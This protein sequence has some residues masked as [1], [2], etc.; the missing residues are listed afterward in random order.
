MSHMDR[1]LNG[2]YH[3]APTI[4]PR[5]VSVFLVIRDRLSK[6]IILLPV[7]SELFDAEGLAD[8]FIKNYVPHHW[9][10]K[11]IVSDRGPQF[12]NTF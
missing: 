3:G 8:I 9:I 7:P 4:R 1:D 5:E 11:A 2:F 6:G 10:P 12:V